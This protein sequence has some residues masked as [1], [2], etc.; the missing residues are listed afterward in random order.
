M[1]DVTTK[2]AT[3]L[4]SVLRRLPPSV[5]ALYV[6]YTDAY[7]GTEEQACFNGFGFEAL[8]GGH[9][10]PTNARHVGEL[11]EFT[12]EPRDE[13]CFRSEDH[14]DTDWLAVLRAA[15]GSPEVMALAAD[16][17]IQFV[18]GEHDGEV[19]VVR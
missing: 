4:Q 3:W 18:V 12:W 5:R 8:A 6:E 15:A 10:D 14:P 13:C 2:A 19:C 16:R 9:F 1:D 17:D 11:G 7:L